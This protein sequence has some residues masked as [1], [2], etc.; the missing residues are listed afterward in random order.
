MISIQGVRNVL[1]EF[2]MDAKSTFFNCE[3]R[4]KCDTSNYKYFARLIHWCTQNN[5]WTSSLESGMSSMYQEDNLRNI[6]SISSYTLLSQSGIMRST[7]ILFQ[8]KS[9]VKDT[10]LESL[11]VP[12]LHPS[13]PDCPPCAPDGC[14]I[15]LFQL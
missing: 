11:G 10:I 6:S 9:M 12:D 13:S 4:E 14:Q 3:A 2:L 1:Q 7:P 5:F 8:T 15:Y